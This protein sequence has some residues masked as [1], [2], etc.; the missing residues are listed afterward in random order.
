MAEKTKDRTE[1]LDDA[2]F[3]T[4]MRNLYN[5][6]PLMIGALRYALSDIQILFTRRSEESWISQD[7]AVGET[8]TAPNPCVYYVP[9][10]YCASLL[11]MVMGRFWRLFLLPLRR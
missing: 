6:K 11:I 10:H 1:R 4:E 7:T 8:A 5:V 2:A 3:H 9:G